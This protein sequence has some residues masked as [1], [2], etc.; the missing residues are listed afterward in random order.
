MSAVA[1]PATQQD[2]AKGNETI[3][4]TTE[5]VTKK[6]NLTR[7]TR[8]TTKQTKHHTTPFHKAI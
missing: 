1:H 2:Q 4:Q 6:H 5:D 8:K 3:K 7:G